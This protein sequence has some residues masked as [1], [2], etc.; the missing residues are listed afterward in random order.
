MIQLAITLGALSGGLVF[1]AVGPV[2]DFTGSAA[3]LALAAVVTLLASRSLSRA[4]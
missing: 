2:A 4:E 1:D 3:I